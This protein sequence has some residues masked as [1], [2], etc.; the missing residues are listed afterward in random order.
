MTPFGYPTDR[1]HCLLDEQPYY[2]VPQRLLPA[3]ENRDDLIVNPSCSFSWHG[4][5]PAD[6]ALRTAFAEGLC[7][8]DWIVWVDDPATQTMWPYWV[9]AEYFDLL[10]PLAPGQ[11]A[12]ADLS[13]Q[14]REVLMTAHILVPPTYAAWRRRRWIDQIAQ[15]SISYQRGY[16]VASGLI[17]PFQLGA[18]RRYFRHQLRIGAYPLG[19]SQVPSRFVGYDEPVSRFVHHQL[20]SI[21]GDI[22]LTLV[23]PSYTYMAAYQGGAELVNHTDRA[24]CEYSV[25]LCIDASPEPE[26]QSLWPIHLDTADGQLKVWQYLGDALFYRGCYVPHGR[27]RLA[28]D[29]TSTSLLFHYVDESFTGP[30]A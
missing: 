13:P 24:Q 20:T 16:V 25:T 14:A 30:L 12:P 18:L 11:P 29:Q 26:E 15:W 6:K 7:P 2:L 21:V 4:A 22:A 5:L 17:P 10:A 27:E 23:R 1:F 19:D 28:D 3:Q 9:G 8:S